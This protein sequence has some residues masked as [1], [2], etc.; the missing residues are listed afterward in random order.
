MKNFIKTPGDVLLLVVFLKVVL[1]PFNPW[2][3]AA[4]GVSALIAYWNREQYREHDDTDQRRALFL[5]DL[6]ER[7]RILEGLKDR[8]EKLSLRF[9][10]V[11]AIVKDKNTT[12]VFG[13]R[14]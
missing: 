11:E 5:Q 13:G 4:L 2:S 1:E 14:R 10:E 8:F 9:E 7:S 6:Q 3:V 12:N